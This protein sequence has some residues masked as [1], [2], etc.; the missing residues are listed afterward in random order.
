MVRSRRFGFT[1]VELLVV[2]AII[3]ILVGL[4]LPAVQAARE[5]ARRMQCGN[6]LKQLGLSMHNYHASFEQFPPGVWTNNNGNGFGTAFSGSS[7][8]IALLPFMEQAPL[9][10][11]IAGTSNVNMPTVPQSSA[12]M[13]AATNQR[14]PSL[15]CPSD[16]NGGKS[17]ENWGLS[18]FNDGICINYAANHGTNGINGTNV[19]SK[20]SMNGVLF[21]L[22]DTRFGSLTDG[23]ANTLMIGEILVIPD[24]GSERDWHGRMY[25]A[26]WASGVLFNSS[27]PPN[28]KTPDQLIRC[29]TSSTD[30][31]VPCVN[32]VSNPT[33]AYLRSRHAGGAQVVMCDGSTQFFTNSMETTLF[34]S[35]GTRGG[36]EVVK[37]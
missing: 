24:S 27:L 30:P 26:D 3:G 35:L 18:D 8:A 11:K 34:F 28:T 7:W 10:D 23:S 6:N 14:I 4:L 5:A 2:I 13:S 22:S 32:N 31:F 20:A 21:G 16:P 9:Y 17:T 36:N 25:R 33:F 1:L 29:Q 37:L 19:A 15:T 12:A